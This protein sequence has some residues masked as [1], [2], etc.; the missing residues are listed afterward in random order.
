MADREPQHSQQQPSSDFFPHFMCTMFLIY[1]LGHGVVSVTLI[2][3]ITSIV[4]AMLIRPSLPLNLIG[5]PIDAAASA[6]AAQMRTP[7]E[8]RAY[9]I[10]YNKGH[11]DGSAQAKLE[12]PRG[13]HRGRRHDRS[14]SGDREHGSRSPLG[15]GIC[16]PKHGHENHHHSVYVEST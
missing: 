14:R 2:L 13:H 16:G 11:T 12:A 10:G 5:S 7:E 3:C 9:T 4:V 1:L 8:V 15:H 6:A